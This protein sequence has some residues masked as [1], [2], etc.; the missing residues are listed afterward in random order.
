MNLWTRFNITIQIRNRIIGGTPVNPQLIEGWVKAHV[1]D[2]SKRAKLVE[3]T[4]EE[5][6]D[7]VTE[8]VDESRC[9]FKRNDMGLYIEGRQLKA[10][11]K[12][13]ANILRPMLEKSE[14]KDT[15][16]SRFTALRAKLAERLFVEEER[17][18][19][20]RL[21]GSRIREPDGNEE[22][23]IHVMTAMG[24]RTALKSVDWVGPCEINF[25][26]KLLNDGVVD[27]DLVKI[28][29]E[30]AG[31]NGLGADR[32]QGNGLFDVTSIIEAEEPRP[33]E[34]DDREAA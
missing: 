21:D 27:I 33:E 16:K 24:P 20:T 12:E 31:E 30:Y 22:R 19:L 7:A 18:H 32:S 1:P 23:A 5:L 17:V 13:A 6:A 9:T 15:K 28:L 10:M 34:A 3:A 29:L 25:T 26:I 8:A 14:K 2:E 11:F 4:K